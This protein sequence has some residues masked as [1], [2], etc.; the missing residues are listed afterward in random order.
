MFGH[1]RTP[2]A[3]VFKYERLALIVTWEVK[4]ELAKCYGS[5]MRVPLIVQYMVHMQKYTIMQ[6]SDIHCILEV[7]HPF[8]KY[9]NQQK[10]QS[11]KKCLKAHYCLHIELKKE[12]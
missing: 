8:R 5:H 11:E 1:G 10:A 6:N 7:H 4:R 9:Q 3:F 2:L 12:I